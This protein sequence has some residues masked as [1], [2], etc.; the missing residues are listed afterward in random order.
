MQIRSGQPSDTDGVL[1]AQPE[2]GRTAG[3]AQRKSEKDIFRGLIVWPLFFAKISFFYFFSA[4]C[5]K[6]VTS[7]ELQLETGVKNG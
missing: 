1:Y 5:K 6:Q 2:R 4:Y 3:E 7:C